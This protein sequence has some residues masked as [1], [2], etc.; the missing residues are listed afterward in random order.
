MRAPGC[1][2]ARPPRA[3]THIPPHG[4][5]CPTRAKP[6]SSP[7][8]SPPAAKPPTPDPTA[9]SA[10]W[11]NVASRRPHH[12]PE[13]PTPLRPTNPPARPPHLDARSRR[14]PERHAAVRLG[15]AREGLSGSHR[16]H[17][18]EPRPQRARR[19]GVARRGF[20]RPEAPARRGG[21]VVFV[22]R[23]AGRGAPHPPTETK[24]CPVAGPVLEAL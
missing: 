22:P 6:P 9:P 10:S 8:S 15:G 16:P 14:A 1:A 12:A 5:L 7:T 24:T 17:A 13:R 3:S 4:A 23:I 19:R 21:G 20:S 2:G 11:L 18:Q